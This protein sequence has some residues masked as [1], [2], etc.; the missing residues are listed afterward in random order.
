MARVPSMYLVVSPVILAAEYG[1]R[2]EHARKNLARV[3]SMYLA[4]SLVI[5]AAEYVHDRTE[6]ARKRWREFRLCA[7][8][9]LL[10]LPPQ[11]INQD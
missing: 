11:N 2:T 5:L 10:G 4:V 1:D 6:H 8:L 9:S 7:L 3:P